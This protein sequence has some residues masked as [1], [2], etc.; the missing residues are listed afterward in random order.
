MTDPAAYFMPLD[1]IGGVWQPWETLGAP[2]G[3][4]NGHLAVTS[5]YDV[6]VTGIYAS[7]L[8]NNVYTW[9]YDSEVFE[10]PGNVTDKSLGFL[11]RPS[12]VVPLKYVP[13]CHE[14]WQP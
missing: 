11:W 12:C 6:F 8:Y 1:P 13:Y 10:D 7:G 4:N 14:E 2:R 5:P 3:F 9:N